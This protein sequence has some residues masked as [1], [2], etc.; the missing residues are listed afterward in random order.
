M[1]TISLN[2]FTN[3]TKFA[4]DMSVIRKTYDSFINIFGSTYDFATTVYLDSHPY[5]EKAR[6]YYNELNTFFTTV[7]YTGS[8]SEGYLESIRTAKTDYIFQCEHDWQFLPTI[9]HNLEDIMY[10]MEER[11]IYHFRFNKRANN[12]AVWDKKMIEREMFI[13]AYPSD[14]SRDMFSYCLSNNM[15]NNPHIIDVKKYRDEIAK[16]IIIRP[17]SKGIEEE[18]NKQ[19][20]YESAIYG[21][22]GYPATV[23]HLDGRGTWAK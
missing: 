4:P 13:D 2:I 19:G 5:I 1:K 16:H 23:R 22:L 7:K 11:G 12:I 9:K 17:G 18:L 10:V 6:N 3:S 21:P 15:S 14:P 8:L 20:K